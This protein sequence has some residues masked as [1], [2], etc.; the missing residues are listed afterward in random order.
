MTKTELI[1]LINSKIYTNGQNLITGDIMNNVLSQMVAFVD[2]LNLLN[3]KK[4]LPISGVVETSTVLNVLVPSTNI[5]LNVAT[6]A[7][8]AL[9]NGEYYSNWETREYYNKTVGSIAYS[10]EDNIY[11]LNGEYICTVRSGILYREI[12]LIPNGIRYTDEEEL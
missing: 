3:I 6:G 8:V 11:I 4:I 7:F 9:Y 5:Y 10:R 1:S 12:S 2:E